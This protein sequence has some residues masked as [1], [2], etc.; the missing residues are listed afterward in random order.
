MGK[1]HGG[2]C[3]DGSIQVARDRP[4]GILRERSAKPVRHRPQVLRCVDVLPPGRRRQGHRLEG[5]DAGELGDGAGEGGVPSLLRPALGIERRRGE[6]ERATVDR[7]VTEFFRERDRT[8]LVQAHP[9]S[10]GPGARIGGVVDEHRRSICR[11]ERFER[12]VAE[13]VVRRDEEES[14]FLGRV[15][16]GR[17][18]RRPVAELPTLGEDGSNAIGCDPVHD[19]GDRTRLVAHDHDDALHPGGEQGSDGSFHQA[20]SPHTDQGLRTTP[21]HRGE[22]FR[23]TRGQH[24]GQPRSAEFDLWSRGLNQRSSRSV[25]G[26]RFGH[27]HPFRTRLI[28]RL[29]GS[30]MTSRRSAVGQDGQPVK[31]SCPRLRSSLPMT[32]RWI[33]DVPSQIRSTRSSRQRRSTGC[34]RI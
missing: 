7:R 26:E 32:I 33:S 24:D 21:G 31:A 14:P 22:P 20:E 1:G 12:A 9:R 27:A 3:R 28:M 11:Q 16:L 4:V 2:A 13:D 19:R 17:S 8:L 34:S 25:L 23:T 18:Q 10:L 5:V 15:R 29:A 30:V 6:E